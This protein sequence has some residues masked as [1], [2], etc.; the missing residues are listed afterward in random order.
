MRMRVQLRQDAL[1]CTAVRPEREGEREGLCGQ[2]I[3]EIT[4]SASLQ[5]PVQSIKVPIEDQLERTRLM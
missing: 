1:P 5:V 3:T 2:L 4:S